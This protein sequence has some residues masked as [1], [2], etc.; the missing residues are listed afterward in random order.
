M[1]ARAYK[2]YAAY[3]DSGVEWLG[4]IPAGWEV[5]RLK[6]SVSNILSGGTPESDNPD[7]WTDESAGTPW[8]AISD[9]TRSFHVHETLRRLTARGLHSKRLPV[10]PR[11]TLL[12]SM[13]ASLGK[14]AILEVDA[15]VNQAILGIITSEDVA[16][17]EYLRWW[18]E[19][20]QGHVQ[21]LSSSSTQDNLNAEKVRSMPI[22]I[23]SSSTQRAIAAFLDR[24]TARIDALVAKKERLITL[25]QERR[26]A[27]ITRAV[28][29]SLDLAA[30]MKGSGVEWLGEIPAHWEVSKMWQISS[31]RSGATPARD[32]RAFWEG[33]IPWVSPKDMKRRV[34]TM[35]EESVTTRA[36]EETGLRLYAPPC[37]LIVVRGMILA[38]SFP[39]A[40]TG[41]PVTINQ[42]M[43]ALTF[44]PA[45][46][47]EFAVRLFEGI[48][49][50]ILATILE[51]AAHGTKAV[52][53]DVWRTLRVPVP[54]IGEQRAIVKFVDHHASRI[55]ALIARIRAAITH[56]H[57]LRTTLI[58]AA[59]TGEID[60]CETAQ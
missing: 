45:M 34:I 1:S 19:F 25:L 2:P 12:Y 29:K 49:R 42:D 54:P 3:K 28:T 52:R 6:N 56:L 50:T 37:V 33:D 27:L 58:S 17:R 20:M 51:E 10:L 32:V 48:G 55:D 38:H 13:Y 4:E 9:M 11:G 7:F 41:A 47:A 39:V 44:T 5:K 14:V 60:V 30:P 46:D 35:S 53:M 57:E 26:T 23:P 36:I 40:I 18:L 24:E 22:V 21:M 8:V 43:K 15:V 16:S 31:A 59:V